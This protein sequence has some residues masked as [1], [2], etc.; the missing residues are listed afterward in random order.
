[1]SQQTTAGHI[2]TMVTQACVMVDINNNR[3]SN[4]KSRKKHYDLN[5]LVTLLH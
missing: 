2:C 3:E 5:E 1:M 4:V